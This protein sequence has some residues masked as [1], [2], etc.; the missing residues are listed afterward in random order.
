MAAV[1]IELTRR[2]DGDG[3]IALAAP[4]GDD[5]VALVDDV[6]ELGAYARCSCAAS[7]DQPY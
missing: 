2:P 6:E 3:G 4:I 5:E 7:D 1:M